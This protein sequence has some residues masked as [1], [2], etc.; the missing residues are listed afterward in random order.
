MEEQLYA[1]IAAWLNTSQRRHIGVEMNR[2][3]V[4]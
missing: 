2:S 4:W 3:V 1:V